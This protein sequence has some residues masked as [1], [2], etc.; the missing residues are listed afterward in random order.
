MKI[1]EAQEIIKKFDEERGWKGDWF[2]K[3]LSLN[4]VEEVGELWSLIKWIDEEKQRKVIEENK[5][6]ASDFIGDSL[7][8]IFKIANKMD[9]DVETALKNTLKDYEKRFP[10][11]ETRKLKHGNKKAGGIDE[12]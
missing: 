9:I 8:L 6:E 11:E 2:I 5:E 1:E 7:F 4:L 10:P 3:D 12:K